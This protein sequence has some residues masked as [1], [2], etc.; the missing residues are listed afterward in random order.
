MAGWVARCR[1]RL[2]A[3]EGA[4]PGA[5]RR[6]VIRDV[7][8]EDVLPDYSALIVG[9]E[10]HPIEELTLE[11]VRLAY[12]GGGAAV[13]AAPPE[14]DDAYPEPSMFGRTPAWGLWTRHVRG[15]TLK[16]VALSTETPDARP[17]TLFED[18]TL[19]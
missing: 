7:T 5:I 18:T 6:V 4:V 14:K 10:G 13:D 1:A 11:R 8:A 9:M 16:D 17:R 19:A 3:P 2:R 15:L 12:R